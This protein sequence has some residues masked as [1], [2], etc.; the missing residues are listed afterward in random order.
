MQIQTEYHGYFLKECLKQD[1][2]CRV[3]RGQASEETTTNSIVKVFNIQLLSLRERQR[4]LQETNLL[5]SLRHPALLPLLEAGIDKGN[6]YLVRAY[7]P[8]GSLVTQLFK[9]NGET[10]PLSTVMNILTRI[11]TAVTY[12]HQKHISHGSIKPENILFDGNRQAFLADIHLTSIRSSTSSAVQT[13]MIVAEEGEQ[14]IQRTAVQDDKERSMQDDIYALSI[15]AYE[16]LTGHQPFTSSSDYDATPVPSSHW[17]PSLSKEVDSV[18]SQALNLHPEERFSSATLFVK[19]LQR[20]LDISI[21]DNAPLVMQKPASLLQIPTQE[22]VLFQPQVEA[23]QAGSTR[24]TGQAPF[25][26]QIFVNKWPSIFSTKSLFIFL[27]VLLILTAVLVPV[28]LFHP[29]SSPTATK[30]HKTQN[31]VPTRQTNSIAP[32]HV[33][34]IISP[35]K[36]QK[37]TP[38]PTQTPMPSSTPVPMPVIVNAG[39]EFPNLNGDYE[40]APGNSG[41]AFSEDCGI[42][43]NGSNLTA[44][45]ANAPSGVQVAFIQA[46][47]TM[48]QNVSFAQGTYRISFLA[49]QRTDSSSTQSLWVIIDNTVVGSFTPVGGNYLYYTTP[50][51]TVGPGIH[52]LQFR[53]LK[54]GAHNTVFIDSV[55]AIH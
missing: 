37:A 26:T 10:F 6:P 46:Y 32:H 55:A 23:R 18:F 4:F 16:L 48:S 12:L 14:K 42:A 49:A 44:N 54:G 30:I 24:F 50:G 47:G 51:F 53:G 3:Y 33:T 5:T 38:I 29:H 40:Y 20:A 19:A 22:L 27:T 52:T 28:F 39:F 7:A 2:Y 41:W 13:P 34:P 45:T 31:Q 25:S 17:T 36:H 9:Q 43:G 15:I 21:Q 8:E 1:E 11:A 35:I